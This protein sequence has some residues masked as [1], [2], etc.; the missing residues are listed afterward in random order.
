M[1]VIRNSTQNGSTQL[2]KSLTQLL[3]RTD[4]GVSQHSASDCIHSRQ[5][6]SSSCRRTIQMQQT[7]L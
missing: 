2:C 3:H 5:K 6:L 7:T 4:R 1:T